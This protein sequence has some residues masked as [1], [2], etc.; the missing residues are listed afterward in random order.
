MRLRFAGAS[1]SSGSRS[2]GRTAPIRG[3]GISKWLRVNEVPVVC[4]D[5]PQICFVNERRRVERSVRLAAQMVVREL[6][7]PLE[8]ERHRTLLCRPPRSAGVGG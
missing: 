6:P 1:G 5:Q 8:D 2:E 7:H 3:G 4:V